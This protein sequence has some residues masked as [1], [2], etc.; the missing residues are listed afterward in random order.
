VNIY[1]DKL[2]LFDEEGKINL[3]FYRFPHSLLQITP[4]TIPVKTS[5]SLQVDIEPV[6]IREEITIKSVYFSGKNY[7]KFHSVISASIE[8]GEK[9][10]LKFRPDNN[11]YFKSIKGHKFLFVPENSL[12]EDL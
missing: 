11:T 1:N 4:K 8:K 3:E 7:A 10:T 12:Q 6:R 2:T 9:L 5:E